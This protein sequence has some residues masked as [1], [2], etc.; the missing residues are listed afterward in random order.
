[1][2]KNIIPLAMSVMVGTC[3]FWIS[4]A[5]MPARTG[6][7]VTMVL[8]GITQQQALVAELPK[9][10]YLTLMDI[11]GYL[12]LFYLIMPLLIFAYVHSRLVGAEKSE[13][14]VAKQMRDTAVNADVRS[15]TAMPISFII[16]FLSMCI[17]G[18]VFMYS[19][20]DQPIKII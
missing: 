16:I 10:S 17:Y 2:G 15:R 14:A 12:C 18:V 19:A 6:F 9:I 3:S 5:A 1:M 8:V 13:A 7:G 11:Y 20:Y 4:P